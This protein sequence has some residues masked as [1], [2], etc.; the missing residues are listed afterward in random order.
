MGKNII[1]AYFRERYAPTF[2]RGPCIYSGG[3]EV[4]RTEACAAPDS[5]LVVCLLRAI[6]VPRKKE[7]DSLI[8]DMQKIPGFFRTWAGTAWADLIASLSE[9]AD[10]AEV[11]AD[12]RE[13]FRGL[14]AG[15]LHQIVALGHVHH[16]RGE[17]TTERRSLVDWA[18]LFAKAGP[19]QRVRSYLLW[20]RRDVDGDGRPLRLAL[21]VE[22]F[23]Q[24]GGG[25]LATLTQRQFADMAS[26]YDVG[27]ASEQCR[28]GGRRAVELCP[29]FVEGLVDIPVLPQPSQNGQEPSHEGNTPSSGNTD[30]GEDHV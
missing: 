23:R 10:S 8:P 7:G 26:L 1:L 28:P 4:S 25:K 15:A 21:R 2:R 13:E 17:T 9:E 30:G 18:S 3:R 12:A 20:S 11:A 19:W 29:E 6:D 24:L 5:P 27:V 14:V 22:L 16:N